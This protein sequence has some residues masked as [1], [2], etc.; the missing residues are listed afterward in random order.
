MISSYV[1]I[2]EQSCGTCIYFSQNNPE[3]D[4][5]DCWWILRNPVPIAYSDNVNSTYRTWGED[6]PCWSG[7]IQ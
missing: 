7:K 6:C 5:G 1:S 4:S 2:N 3:I